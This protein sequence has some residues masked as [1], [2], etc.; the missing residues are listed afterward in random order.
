MDDGRLVVETLGPLAAYVDGKEVE[1]GP[2][3][4]RAAFVVLAL[5]AGAEVS[6]DELVDHI[7]GD[8]P[9]AT[10][11]G[12]LHTYVSGLRH[13]LGPG[14]AVLRSSAT[15]Y[16]LDI[17]EDDL[18]ERVAERLMT[19]SRY[20][21]AAGDRHRAL[22]ELDRAL[23]LW[24]SPTALGNVP[25]P[26]AAEQRTRLAAA[27]LR[28]LIDR[29]ELVADCSSDLADIA[30]AADRLA[31]EVATS[32]YD[33]RLRVAL[34]NALHSSGRTADALA[35]YDSLRRTLADE[36]GID[37]ATSTQAAHA[38]ILA[39][40]HPAVAEP[41]PA[42]AFPLP[43][44]A[45]SDD[46][47]PTP[48]PAQL[49]PDDRA[50]VGR[51]DHLVA[52]LRA[53]TAPTNDGDEGGLRI[54]TV[55]GIGGV[56]KTALAIRCG[57]MLRDRFPDGQIYLNLRGF[58]DR[59]SPRSPSSALGHLLASV[60]VLSAPQDYDQRVALWR[61]TVADRRMLV[62]LDNAVS[63]E[64][65]EDL[66]PGAPRSFVMVTSRNRLSGL[67]VRHSARRIALEPLSD[68]E[69]LALLTNAVGRD[70]V[71][72]Q[73]EATQRLIEL[74]DRL[75]I[76]LRVA[77]EQVPAESSSGMAQLVERLEGAVQRL[78]VLELADGEFG[79]LRGV[80]SCSLQALG[81]DAARAF[82]LLGSVPVGSTTVG[83][84]A[85]LLDLPL[86]CAAVVL[87]DLRAHHLLT[88]AHGH[89]AML[90]LTRS[91]AAETAA[92]LPSQERHD[93][94]ARILSW[95]VTTLVEGAHSSLPF[96]SPAAPYPVPTLKDERALLRWCVP[97]LP[98]LTALVR[99][100][101]MH[102]H[103]ERAW[104]LAALLFVPFYSS[105]DAHEWLDVLR[106]AMRSADALGDRRARAVLLNH[107]SVA[108]SR[109]GRNDLAVQRL[110]EALDLLGGDHWWY[111][112]SLLGNLSSTLREAKEYEA[113]L[114]SAVA[115]LGLAE[116]LGDDYYIGAM[117]DTVCELFTE[118]G[119]WREAVRH[120]VPGLER[121]R[122]SGSQVL[123]ANLLI[124]LGLASD[125]LDDTDAAEHYFAE[126][127]RM[128][129][130]VGD[131]YH[132]G[133]AL[134]GLARVRSSRSDDLARQAACDLAEQAL[135]RFH[136][137]GSEE[138]MA[139]REFH[140][141]LRLAA[142]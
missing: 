88:T 15:G 71:L 124:N 102:G 29:T 5:R 117:Q 74:C 27:R 64:Q 136:E 126:A 54:V 41:V 128:C 91:F 123:E 70:Q 18:D 43:P 104:Q 122:K 35:Q 115:G 98:N 39:A 28:L 141:S 59:H 4:R 119:R 24:R 130:E 112:V 101:Q 19:S 111:R 21:R 13:A 40:D 139:V 66:L 37:P 94:L 31:A 11:R 96:E 116:Q 77:A 17:R 52:M 113:A 73:P 105:G 67:A 53:A 127:L 10:A 65:V 48:D 140:S 80:L 42:P 26:F 132:E 58:D 83:A 86:R 95:Y 57:H 38:T 82:R 8:T 81:D 47:R 93:A 78:D 2:P 16:S 100:A 63:A 109:L 79:S 68:P 138:E 84:V 46:G 85:A 49:P 118:L 114:D 45:P 6:R 134:F 75:P 22:G 3:K 72:V 103:H 12:S 7:W 92:A 142:Y 30:A 9:P 90:D 69:S 50:F 23:A 60:G 137:L 33:E 87:S 32:P 125:G 56:G 107:G 14:R 99:E 135:V 76:A 44:H 55:V 108:C 25:G 121:V 133:L 131:R 1:L 106:I 97:E 34:M 129:A 110:H 20:A 61:S 62:L 36:L 51:D 89:Y 120:G